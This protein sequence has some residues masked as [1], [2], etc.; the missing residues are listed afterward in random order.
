MTALPTPSLP[1]YP[2]PR[3]WEGLSA[4]VL[5]H[6][7]LAAE[8]FGAIAKLIGKNGTTRT[9]MLN[10]KDIEEA[11]FE[12]LHDVVGDLRGWADMQAEEAKHT[13]YSTDA[14]IYDRRMAM[15]AGE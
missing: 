4:D 11:V 6:A 3:D 2:T 7:R 12:A 1:L 8:H 15:L 13:D 14:A 9:D 10:P 5:H